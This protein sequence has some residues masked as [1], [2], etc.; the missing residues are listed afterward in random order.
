MEW[1]GRR[2]GEGRRYIQVEETDGRKREE[3]GM[4]GIG[5]EKQGKGKEGGGRKMGKER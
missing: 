1:E 3:E 4:K 2:E 5:S